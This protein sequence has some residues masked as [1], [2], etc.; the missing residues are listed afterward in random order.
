MMFVE[1]IETV[2]RSKA[3]QP[4]PNEKEPRQLSPGSLEKGILDAKTEP[5]EPP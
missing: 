3:S 4:K 2:N 1:D 5:P